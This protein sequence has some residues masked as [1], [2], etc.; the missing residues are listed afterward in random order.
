MDEMQRER[1]E[2]DLRNWGAWARSGS[3][4]QGTCGS[5]E[6][7]YI[8]LRDDDNTRGEQQ[9]LMPIRRGA[10]ELMDAAISKLRDADHRAIV[11][12]QY[13][14]RYD[15]TTIAA[16]F[17][18]AVMMLKA[19]RL[20]ALSGLQQQIDCMTDQVLKPSRAR[21]LLQSKG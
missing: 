11:K 8:P 4:V 14:D 16:H 18:V 17:N 13:Y 21:S 1:L 9:A 19:R 2:Q 6:R 15:L 5:A 12:L 10:A 20:I 7:R 3:S